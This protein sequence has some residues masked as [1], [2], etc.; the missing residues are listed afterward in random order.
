MQAARDPS[1]DRLLMAIADLPYPNRDTLAFLCVHLQ[2]VARRA[3]ENKMPAENLARC[4]G[5]SVLMGGRRDMNTLE[6]NIDQQY[7]EADKQRKVMQCF[8]LLPEEYW[9]SYLNSRMLVVS[10]QLRAASRTP[11]MNTPRNADQSMLGPV[12]ETPPSSFTPTMRSARRQY[13]AMPR[14]F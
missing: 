11:L 13:R 9:E 14:E 2:K 1:N 10:S 3:N 12:S 8:L 4:I 5:V 7:S 6:H